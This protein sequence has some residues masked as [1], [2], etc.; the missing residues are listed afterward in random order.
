M[1]RAMRA[2]GRPSLLA[3]FTAGAVSLAAAGFASAA[4]L[5]VGT[6][7]LGSGWAPSPGCTTAGLSVLS[8]LSGSSVVSVT[9]AAVPAAC[10]GA[11]LAVTVTNGSATGSGSASVPAEGGSVTVSLGSATPI[12]TRLETDLVLVGP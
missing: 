2:P 5:H 12:T 10:A 3:A 11:T 7:G 9:V 1:R 8:N 4:N 6:A